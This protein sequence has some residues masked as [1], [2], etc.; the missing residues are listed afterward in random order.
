MGDGLGIR[1]NHLKGVYA[2]KYGNTAIMQGG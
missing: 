1:N 2:L